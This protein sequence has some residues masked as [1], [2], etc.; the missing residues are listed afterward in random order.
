MNRQVRRVYRFVF[1]G[2]ERAI[3]PQFM[4]GTRDAIATLPACAILEQTERRV[5]AEEL[6]PL[7]FYFEQPTGTPLNLEAPQ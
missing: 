2:A 3:S 1:E 6:D 4:W 7:G 5:E